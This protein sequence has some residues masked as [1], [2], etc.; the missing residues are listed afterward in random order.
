M[1]KEN[2]YF[3]IGVIIAFALFFAYDYVQDKAMP[4][5]KA[6]LIECFYLDYKPDPNENQFRFVFNI[7]NIGYVPTHAGATICVDGDLEYSARC[8]KFD[9]IY[10]RDNP[11]LDMNSLDNELNFYFESEME[12]QDQNYRLVYYPEANSKDSKIIY[13]SSTSDCEDAVDFD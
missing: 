12:R 1:K 8:I 10:D 6:D 11:I 4:N 3:I 9:K 5:L 2:Y 13:E 7:V